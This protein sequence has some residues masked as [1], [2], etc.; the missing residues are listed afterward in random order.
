MKVYDKSVYVCGEGD[1][2]LHWTH[3]L[4]NGG[5][6]RFKWFETPEECNIFAEI[7]MF[8]RSIIYGKLLMF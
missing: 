5:T 2:Q 8:L 6:V 1:Y 4:E 3:F 7:L